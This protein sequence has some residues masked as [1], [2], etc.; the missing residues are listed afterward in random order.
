MGADIQK[1]K[2]Q[3]EPVARQ[4]GVK[5]VYLFGSQARGDATEDSDYDF[6]IDKGA[7][8]GFAVFGFEIA[9][10]K[11]LNRE[12]DIVTSGMRNERLKRSIERD[13]VLLYEA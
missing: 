8:R 1:L 13:K 5:T 12:V 7:L 9:L 3:I 10:E 2:E 11:L 6:F 4:Y